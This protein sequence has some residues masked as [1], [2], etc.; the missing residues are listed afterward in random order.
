MKQTVVYFN[1][2]DRA[3]G[4]SVGTLYAENTVV[5]QPL[6]IGLFDVELEE[7]E[8]VWVKRWNRSVLIS[9]VGKDAIKD[10]NGIRPPSQREITTSPENK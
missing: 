4:V 2:S 3:V 10:L 5:L 7:G 6:Q 8:A 9:K 1:D